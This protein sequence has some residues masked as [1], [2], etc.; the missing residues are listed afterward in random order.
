M[1]DNN[2]PEQPKPQQDGGTPVRSPIESGPQSQGVNISRRGFLS[3][4]AGAGALAFMRRDQ[5]QAADKPTYAISTSEHQTLMSLNQILNKSLINKEELIK[6]PVHIL[7]SARQ[8]NI[9]GETTSEY[10]LV[11]D[12]RVNITRVYSRTRQSDGVFS[13]TSL[14]GNVAMKDAK[15]VAVDGKG[16]VVVVGQK[17]DAISSPAAVEVRYANSA[18]FLNVPVEYGQGVNGG[19]ITQAFSAGKDDT[20]L[21]STQEGLQIL[22]IDPQIVDIQKRARL[23]AAAVTL[24]PTNLTIGRVIGLALPSDIQAQSSNIEFYA[25]I[26]KNAQ[27]GIIKIKLDTITG[28]GEA[29]QLFPEIGSVDKPSLY[30]DP[31][32]GD[33][34]MVTLNTSSEDFF[35]LNLTQNKIDNTFNYVNLISGFHKNLPPGAINGGNMVGACL[36]EDTYSA[37]FSY[38]NT[39]DGSFRP[40]IVSW[41]KGINPATSPDKAKMYFPFDE[42]KINGAALSMHV[43]TYQN[44]LKALAFAVLGVRISTG[45]GAVEIPLGS[46]GTLPSNSDG[47]PDYS[48]TIFPNK[49][50]QTFNVEVPAARTN[51][52][53]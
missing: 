22:T 2:P 41:K 53:Q 25:T 49:R 51:S 27:N 35:D 24:K 29:E 43:K 31:V 45:L 30:K 10:F 9:N 6:N 16:N 38:L 42:D 14:V 36:V 20:F 50:M 19:D 8:E 7:S 34:H 23:T 11:E 47:T 28:V 33:D 44:G 32:T 26:A 18:E 40:A 1:P 48:P 5:V 21:L 13:E 39:K 46:D 12:K 52:P 4:L 3:A 15:S 37:L 17:T